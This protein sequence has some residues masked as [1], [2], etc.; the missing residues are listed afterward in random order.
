M[1]MREFLN[2]F[3]REES[4]GIS[5]LS[6]IYRKLMIL[7]KDKS[8]KKIMVTSALSFEG[9][10][11]FATLFALTLAKFNKTKIL[12][13]DGDF[14]KPK[15]HEYFNLPRKTGLSELILDKT[16][17]DICCKATM[18]ENL[19]VMTCGDVKDTLVLMTQMLMINELF[20][21]ITTIFDH[22][23]ID[24]PPV[25]PVSEPVLLAKDMDGILLVV[26]AGKTQREIVKHTVDLLKGAGGNILGVIL[27]D[28]GQSLPYYYYR[29]YYY[30]YYNKDMKSI[31]KR[32]VEA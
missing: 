1:K 30:K 27:N 8:L 13:V 32:L 24:C 4:Q 5:D 25:M 15:I 21:K 19:R 26:K 6:R 14:R 22:I 9:K 18:L 31:K 7:H 23:I 17:V 20:D 29:S 28:C 3:F 16:P 10:S 11:T 2:T 12:L